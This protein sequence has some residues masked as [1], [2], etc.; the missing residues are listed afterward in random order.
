MESHGPTM[1]HLISG[2]P[3]HIRYS[4]VQRTVD[5]LGGMTAVVAP[6]ADPDSRNEKRDTRLANCLRR[7]AAAQG[8]WK[9]VPVTLYMMPVEYAI[10][11]ANPDQIRL[12][13]QELPDHV[14]ILTAV[15]GSRIIAPSD[16]S[17]NFEDWQARV[18]K[19]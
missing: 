6:Y 8:G 7:M 15:D 4:L 5:S 19:R 13:S 14:W 18:P 1:A 10:P 11:G 3:V 2:V 16:Y 9:N 12:V 17:D